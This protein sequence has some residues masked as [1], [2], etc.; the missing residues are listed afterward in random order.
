[1]GACCVIAAFIL[2]Q[3]IETL[4]R[5]GMFWG[6]V[7]VPEGETAATLFSTIRGYL[8]LPK[9]RAAISVLAAVE[10]IAVC[11]WLYIAHGTHIVQ[12]ADIGWQHLHGRQVI[13]SKMC[14]KNGLLSERIVLP[15]DTR[16][17][18]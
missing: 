12:L 14:S 7:A 6:I 15:I 18:S 10:I 5:W 13:Y 17:G 16:R 11:S 9:V 2:A 4:R 3:C 1:M 8:I